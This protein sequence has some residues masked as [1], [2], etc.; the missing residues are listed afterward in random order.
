MKAL[1]A[2]SGGVDSSVAALLTKESGYDCIGCTMKL[3]DL[4]EEDAGAVKPSKTCCSLDD[5]EDAR[6]VAFRL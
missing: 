2:M 4:P 3:W 6:S 1:I 5:T